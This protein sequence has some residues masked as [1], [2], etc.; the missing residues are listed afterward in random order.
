MKSLMTGLALL[1]LA[2][3]PAPAGSTAPDGK[4]SQPAK[5]SLRLKSSAH[6]GYAP[7]TIQLDG[8]I[9][10]AAEEDL[11]SCLISEEW[12]GE[13]FTSGPPLNT[14]KKIPCV[15]TLNDGKV[16]RSFHRDVTLEEPGMYIYQL[17]ITPSGQRTIAS[18]T[19]EIKVM[20]SKYRVKGAT[21]GS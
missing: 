19:L 16:P 11:N 8:E 15:T 1:A 13:T 2:T 10:G 7:L 9:L 14:K 12:T 17:L 20:S 6:N 3:M 4:A 18:R 21:P 5:I